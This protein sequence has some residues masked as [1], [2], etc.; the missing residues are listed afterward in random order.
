MGLP[1][2]YMVACMDELGLTCRAQL[3]WRKHP[4]MPERVRDRCPTAHEVILHF[5]RTDR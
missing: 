5:T 3:I 1:E 2:R 4:P